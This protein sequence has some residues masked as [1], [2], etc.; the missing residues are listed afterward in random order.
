MVRNDC[1]A[2]VTGEVNLD[3]LK[4]KGTIGRFSDHNDGTGREA[5]S[6]ILVFN[7]AS[8]VWA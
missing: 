2:K 4:E 6:D 5:T 3:V 1:P 8:K 7:L